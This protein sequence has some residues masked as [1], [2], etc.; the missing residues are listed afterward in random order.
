MLVNAASGSGPLVARILSQ[1]GAD[2]HGGGGQAADGENRSGAL[3]L[4]DLNDLIL[5]S[6][7][8]D[9]NSPDPV[10]PG[11]Y[12][13]PRY[14]EFLGRAKEWLAASFP[15]SGLFVIEDPRIGRLMPF[16]LA[17]LQECGVA[18]AVLSVC[19]PVHATAQG[20][21]VDSLQDDVTGLGR[22]RSMLDA[23]H[24]TRSVPRT[25]LAASSLD[26]DWEGAIARAG[27]DL[28][29]SWPAWTSR[30]R[31]AI[32]RELRGQSGGANQRQGAAPAGAAG[33]FGQRWIDDAQAI[34]GRWCERGE[35]ADDRGDLDELRAELD[36]AM[37]YL[38]AA[39]ETIVALAR[40]LRDSRES[41]AVLLQKLDGI[42]R[43]TAAGLAP[44][45]H[46]V[47]GIQG[48]IGEAEAACTGILEAAPRDEADF[49]ERLAQVNQ[50]WARVFASSR[51]A[52]SNLTEQ[53]QTFQDTVTQLAAELDV[54]RD[55]LAASDS[56][57]A[58]LATLA[59]AKQ[60]KATQRYVDEVE[61]LGA[62]VA[63]RKDVVV[64]LRGNLDKRTE[65]VNQLRANL[66]ARDSTIGQLRNELNAARA[67]AAT[68]P[69]GRTGSRRPK[70]QSPSML[71]VAAGI[72]VPK[73]RRKALRLK[74]EGRLVEGSGLFDAQWYLARYPDV[75]AAGMDALDHFMRFGGAEG[76]HPSERFNSRWYLEHYSDVREAGLNPLLHYLKFGHDEGRSCKALGGGGLDAGSF[77]GTDLGPVDMPVAVGFSGKAMAVAEAAASEFGQTWRA[78]GQGWLGLGKPA[79]RGRNVRLRADLAAEAAGPG[80]AI[81]EEVIA[82]VG[83]AVAE[84]ARLGLFTALR[85]D[86]AVLAGSA[87][88]GGDLPAPHVLLA[89][90]GLGLDMLADAWFDGEVNLKLRMAPRTDEGVLRAYQLAPD[91]TI[92]CI[93]ETVLAG[94]DIDLG[95]ARLINP[96]L[97]VLLVLTDDSGALCRTAVL[98]FPSLL[99][100]GLHYGELA[101]IEAAPGYWRSLCDY[102]HSLALELFGWP[103]APA[104]HSLARL[105]ID[106]R[107]ATGI[108]PIFRA[109]V[110]AALASQ[111]GIAAGPLDLSSGDA[112]PE[113]M[114]CLDA[115]S[116]AH[117][118]DR[119]DGGAT[120]VLP[121]D[122]LPSLYSL[123]SRRA[124]DRGAT[125]LVVVDAATLKPSACVHA[126]VFQPE[127]VRLQH[128][129]LPGHL[130]YLLPPAAGW[131][132][133]SAA[134]L[135]AT[136]AIR[137]FNPLSWPVDP[138]APVSPDQCLPVAASLPNASEGGGPAVGVIVDLAGRGGDPTQ[139]LASLAGQTVTAGMEIVVAG[140]GADVDISDWTA[141]VPA[142][143]TIRCLQAAGLTR[144]AR[145]NAAAAMTN[146]SRIL[147][148]DPSLVLGDPRTI[149][150]LLA[151]SNLPGAA[152]AA[153]ALVTE[154]DDETH[155]MLHS[156]GYF[157]TRVA[158]NGDPV[159]TINEVHVGA[160]L[161]A[162][163]YPVAANHGR[164]CM[165]T[166]AA[167][168][169][170]GG[171]D[172]SRFPEA[173]HDLDFG[174]RALAAGYDNCCTTLVRAATDAAAPAA[175]FP[176]P[177]GHRSIRPADAQAL[178]D[179]VTVVRELR[180]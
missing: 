51:D 180:R 34:F 50:R 9:L 157:P 16:W 24:A 148:L 86:L 103:E 153:C 106:M 67:L 42:G 163:T 14:A 56:E 108:E 161:P 85:P 1:L 70:R 39:V 87:T 127:L 62:L 77:S 143:V 44:L 20:D 81:G 112:S 115:G 32:G 92:H 141:I 33:A 173:V 35:T 43:A 133:D 28:S 53:N 22:L 23:E 47:E 59:F 140:V 40:E 19:E 91:G 132:Q 10:G 49:A 152:T 116:A 142:D 93:A 137:Y 48:A 136:R 138:L 105:A 74:A 69:A 41:C 29:L 78:S 144:A 167:W 178:F 128:P 58:R 38:G 166:R 120:L 164:C 177:V 7:G 146:S 79:A 169:A 114:A 147:F 82:T 26:E 100:G 156:A 3:A 130:P 125:G 126:P 104:S 131:S 95:E 119:D 89:S 8:T 57:I 52:Q 83:E 61:A 176:D 168:D 111:Y 11:W 18:P 4:A 129:D 84:R 98:P 46:E 65:T 96:L 151:M 37:E 64:K 99:R 21:A 88:E 154:G 102:A 75:A 134:G 12:A 36:Q 149:Q 15:H 90:V 122:T 158:L 31:N 27:R 145:L 121:A 54:L 94:S 179:R 66:A 2:H 172:A 68:A 72:L 171:F 17:V 63:E 159:L 6:A 101:A 117:G 55:K 30:T 71:M 170:L 13:S 5:A 175:D 162:A 155:G 123:V 165:I 60:A 80:I 124:D 174:L 118:F 45:R 135:P 73:S 139:L 25:Y 109:D 76:R 160:I 113:L 150:V 97:G 107:G 110:V